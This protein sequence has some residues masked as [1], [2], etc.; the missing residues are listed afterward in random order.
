MVAEP[1]AA[2]QD[3]GV[4]VAFSTMAAGWVTVAALEVVQPF[5]SVTVT[6]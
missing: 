1:F 3:A 6:K 4:A 5:P 2:P